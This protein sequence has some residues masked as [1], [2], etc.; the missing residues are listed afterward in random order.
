MK[1]IAIV[2]LVIG[3]VLSYSCKKEEK[4]VATTINGTLIVN[5]TNDPIKISTELKKPQVILYHRHGGGVLG[6]GG[7]QWD[8]IDKTIV[9]NSAKYSFDKELLSGEEYFLV[10]TD[11]NPDLYWDN[12]NSY[13]T[14]LFPITAGQ[15]NN[16]KLYVLAY[17][18]VRPRFINTNP[19]VNNSDVFKYVSGLPCDNCGSAGLPPVFHGLTDSTLNWVG[20]TWGGTNKFGIPP[21]QNN[22]NPHEVHG[23]LTRNGVTRDTI[24]YY[25]V[26]PY[27]TTIVEIRY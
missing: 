2:I 18:W 11:C 26:P 21:G 13:N 19:D 3:I 15:N 25:S 7:P 16:I 9:N 17:S 5:G 8:E 20:K 23:K 22:Y 14:T 27:D 1:K 24:I 10:Y 12:I 4:K 6:G